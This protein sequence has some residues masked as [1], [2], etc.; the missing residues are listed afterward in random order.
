[1][2][3]KVGKKKLQMVIMSEKVGTKKKHFAD[4]L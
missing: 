3:E 2:S 1:M 4:W